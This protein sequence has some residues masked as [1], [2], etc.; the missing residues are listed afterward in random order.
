MSERNLRILVT[1]DEEVMRKFL[2]EVLRS[3]GYTCDEA[4]NGRECLHKFSLGP[5]YDV[6]FVDLVMPRMDGEATLRELRSKYPKTKVIVC[7]VQDDEEAIRE[8]LAE[9]ATAYLTKPVKPDELAG[10]MERL[11]KSEA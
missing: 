3:L 4:S 10:V 2:V 6:A 11:E 8:L 1:D 9:G 7:S 5:A